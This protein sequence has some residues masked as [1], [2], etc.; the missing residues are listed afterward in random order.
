LLTVTANLDGTLSTDA[1]FSHP[2]GRWFELHHGVFQEAGRKDKMAFR[3]DDRGRVTHALMEPEAFE[4]EAWYDWR[5]LHWAFVLM[6]AALFLSGCVGWP[7]AALVRRLRR[8]RAGVN[9]ARRTAVV[10]LGTVCA[11]NLAYPP[12]FNLAVT[13]HG[14]D[15]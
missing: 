1:F 3:V 6:C 13:L 10:L 15:F 8:R 11:L 5:P 12:L 2:A 7:I 14:R 9:T 4:K